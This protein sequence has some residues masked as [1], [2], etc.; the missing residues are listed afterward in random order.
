[1]SRM[2]NTLLFPSDDDAQVSKRRRG[3]VGADARGRG[4]SRVSSARGRPTSLRDR[5]PVPKSRSHPTRG[6]R[7]KPFTHRQ[8]WRGSQHELV[9]ATDDD[10][11]EGSRADEEEGGRRTRR[12]ST[13]RM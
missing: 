4:D 10:D 9:R 6:T 2:G 11:D 3:R 5:A 13:S 8:G 1:M 12:A 7:G